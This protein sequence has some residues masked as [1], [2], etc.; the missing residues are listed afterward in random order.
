MSSEVTCTL[1][2]TLNCTRY[3]TDYDRNTRLA[4]LDAPDGP[5]VAIILA[6][7]GLVRLGLGDR[8]TSDLHPPVLHHAVGQ[9]ALAIEIRSSDSRARELCQTLTHWQTHWMCFA[10]RALLRVLEGGCSVPVGAASSLE[11][12]ASGIR[13]LKLTGCVTSLGGDTHIEMTLEDKVKNVEEAERLGERLAKLL[14]E[15]GAKEI[16]DAITKDR[17][18]KTFA[19][20]VPASNT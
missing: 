3:L 7:A 9:G 14:I 17:E 5:F 8:V 13:V 2:G 16:L 18:E 15:N 1:T 11:E 10:E 19:E 4:K 12:D 6:K 20:S